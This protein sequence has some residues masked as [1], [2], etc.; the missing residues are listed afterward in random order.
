MKIGDKFKL[1][2]KVPG[3]CKGEIVTYQG[4]YNDDKYKFSSFQGNILTMIEENISRVLKEP[5]SKPI[6]NRK[7]SIFK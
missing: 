4:I 6:G 3:F 1:K 5:D 2:S 7:T